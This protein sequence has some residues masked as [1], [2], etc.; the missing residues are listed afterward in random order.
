MLKS[1]KNHLRIGAAAL[2]VTITLGT[3]AAF[4]LYKPAPQSYTVCSDDGYY[5]E[6]TYYLTEDAYNNNIPASDN[7]DK[8]VRRAAKA[9]S[10]SSNSNDEEFVLG[11]VKTVW[12]KE[13]SDEDGNITESELLTKEEVDEI[14]NIG[15]ED[16]S[17]D[18]G[19]D[20]ETAQPDM[21][22]PNR[23]G[24]GGGGGPVETTVG[25]DSGSLYLLNIS[26]E[27]VYNA[28]KEE[29]S[30][31]GQA[32]WAE[33]LVWYQDEY[34]AAEESSLDYIAMTWGGDSVL[35]ATSKTISG[36]YYDGDAAVQFSRAKS[37]SYAGYV[38]QFHEKEYKYGD[39]LENA[40][41][42]VTL[43]RVGAMQN[44]ET[45]IK[46]TY[47]HTFDEFNYT[48]SFSIGFDASL[49]GEISFSAEVSVDMSTED[50]Q[51]QIELDVP[52]IMY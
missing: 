5:S 27:V 50:D 39:E 32:S 48:P 37:D 11:A 38:W 16:A 31:T 24:D 17:A 2:A 21:L 42:N 52:N 14:G 43:A 49:T 33:Q 46:L 19:E 12:V 35:K 8:T 7:S 3:V 36:K 9:S 29:Y 28:S 4:A 10:G 51:W 18:I 34:K 6:T 47:I 1:K 23:P 30:A 40:T 20:P 26:M 15:S 25:T 13:T 44:K 22:V 45:C 41:A